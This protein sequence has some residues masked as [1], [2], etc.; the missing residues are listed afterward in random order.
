MEDLIVCDMIEP[1]GVMSDIRRALVAHEMAPPAPGDEA[2][3]WRDKLVRKEYAMLSEEDRKTP[4]TMRDFLE[5]AEHIQALPDSEK[6]EG[7]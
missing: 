2:L 5:W 1:F 7:M 6:P 4:G 3:D